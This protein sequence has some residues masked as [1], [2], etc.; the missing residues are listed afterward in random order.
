MAEKDVNVINH[1]LDIEHQANGMITEAQAEADKR[2]NAFRT[3][4]E[5]DYKKQYEEI[6]AGLESD[7]KTRTE[8]IARN[9]TEAVKQ[10]KAD[11]VN[12]VQNK[13]AF[14]KRLETLLFSN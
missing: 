14:N 3:R 5:A 9:R 10:Y 12:T 6:I 1:L 4:A 11:V 7:Y 8:E 13:E 2:L